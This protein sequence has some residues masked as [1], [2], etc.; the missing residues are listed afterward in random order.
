MLRNRVG[1]IYFDAKAREEARLKLAECVLAA[2]RHDSTDADEIE[3]LALGMFR[4]PN[5]P[6]KD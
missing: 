2:T 5:P 4:F 3:S 1:I 6:M